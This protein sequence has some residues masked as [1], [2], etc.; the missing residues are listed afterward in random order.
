MI[1]TVYYRTMDEEDKFDVEYVNLFYPE[2]DLVDVFNHNFK[3][4][5]VRD[6][7]IA[8]SLIVKIEI[9]SSDLYS[10]PFF[11]KLKVVK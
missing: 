3:K 5:L 10:L 9:Q 2:G 7:N 11:P 6:L 4:K 1:V 8:T